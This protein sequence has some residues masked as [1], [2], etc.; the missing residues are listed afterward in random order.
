[1]RAIWIAFVAVYAWPLWAG[2]LGALAAWAACW[3][4]G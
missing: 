4:G 2:L 1:M 3:I